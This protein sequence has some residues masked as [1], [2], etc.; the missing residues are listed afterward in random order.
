MD[1]TQLKAARL[2]LGMTQAGVADAL[3]VTSTF[4]SMMERGDRPIERRTA[5]AMLALLMRPQ[6]A[7]AKSDELDDRI[8]ELPS[9]TGL[10][11]RSDDGAVAEARTPPKNDD[12][13]TDADVRMDP[14]IRQGIRDILHIAE[15]LKTHLDAS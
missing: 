5:L 4:I 9:S 1:R 10:P 6:L 3:G 11:T 13:R 7:S 14:R 2:R 12:G 8:S 15:G